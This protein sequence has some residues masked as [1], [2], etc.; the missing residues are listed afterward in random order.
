MPQT[1]PHC[2]PQVLLSVPRRSTAKLFQQSMTLGEV[3]M[4]RT[5]MLWL[6][7]FW[8]HQTRLPW[9]TTVYLILQSLTKNVS[10]PTQPQQGPT[11]ALE[12]NSLLDIFVL[13][14][15]SGHQH[16]LNTVLLALQPHGIL[17]VSTLVHQDGAW[18]QFN[19]QPAPI[20]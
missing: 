10:T 16:L 3:W 19:D 9:R 4:L 14:N 11:I 2:S 15:K 1:L 20:L 6:R 13:D 12:N 7:K 5:K 8:A 18:I 17:P